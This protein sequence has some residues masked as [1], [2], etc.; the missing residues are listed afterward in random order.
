[1]P[2]ADGDVVLFDYTLWVDGKPVDTSEEQRAKALGIHREGRRYRSL[3]VVLG[4]KQIITGLESHLR[5]HGQVGVTAKVEVAAEDAYGARDP[6]RIKDVPMAQFRAKKVAPEVGMA[7][8]LG[9]ERG[10]V[11]RVAGGGVRV[12]LNHDL[13]GKPLTYEYTVRGVVQEERAKVEAILDGVFPAGGY[14]VDVG[15]AVTIEVPDPLKFDADWA[16]AKFS[17]VAQLRRVTPKPIRLVE[18]YAEPTA[19]APPA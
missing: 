11:T 12:D 7:L 9:G 14:K 4:A 5:S 6:H 16:M 19:V 15:A 18:V 3:T 17:V 1:M 13:A 8:T 10:V 2:L